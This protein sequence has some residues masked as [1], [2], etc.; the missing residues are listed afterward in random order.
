MGG[1]GYSQF[2]QR[3]RGRL[4]P[5]SKVITSPVQPLAPSLSVLSEKSI[6]SAELTQCYHLDNLG[7]KDSTLKAS[8]TSDF[9]TDSL[10]R[11][12]VGHI[13]TPSPHTATP[14]PV[15][16]DDSAKLFP[17]TPGT[18]HH[19]PNLVINYAVQDGTT[20]LSPIWNRMQ[21]LFTESDSSSNSEYITSYIGRTTPSPRRVECGGKRVGADSGQGESSDEE[22]S[23]DSDGSDSG[24]ACEPGE[25]CGSSHQ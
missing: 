7:S 25:V 18:A 10:E 6:E 22:G 23:E 9:E 24:D 8:S 19:Q 5:L 12:H 21:R 17:P 16:V 1:T 4:Q 3:G 11:N 14:S 13:V 2:L 20:T 15:L